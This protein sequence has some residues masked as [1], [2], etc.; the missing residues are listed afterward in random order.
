[1]N[2]SRRGDQCVRQ[3]NSRR[4]PETSGRFGEVAVDRDLDERV[5]VTPTGD[6][7][8]ALD[9]Q[10]ELA[11]RPP[12]GVLLERVAPGEHE[13]HHGG[14][15]CLTEGERPDDCDQRDQV[16][17]D[18]EPHQ[19]PEH[20]PGERDQDEDSRGREDA[21]G[22]RVIAEQPDGGPGADAG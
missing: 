22:R 20:R 6:A 15:Q 21:V 9:Q 16:D 4:S 2:V 17:A 3:R 7:R 5:P 10:R 19:A 1:M 13:S 18:V 11:A 12:V 8:R 14:R